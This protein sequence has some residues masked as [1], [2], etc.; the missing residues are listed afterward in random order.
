MNKPGSR[1]FRQL[2]RLL[3]VV[4]TSALAL[5]VGHAAK[6]RPAARPR[7]GGRFTAVPSMRRARHARHAGAH[8]VINR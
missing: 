5:A 2:A 1:M 3:S 6:I 8:V 4:L 7:H